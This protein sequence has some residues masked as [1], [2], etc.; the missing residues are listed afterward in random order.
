MQQRFFAEKAV[1]VDIDWDKISSVVQSDEGKRELASL[2]NTLLELERTVSHVETE[3][4]SPN[5]EGLKKQLDAKIVENFQKAYGGR[6][7]VGLG[8]CGGVWGIG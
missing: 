2:K 7:L 3:V 5:W 1:A 8:G 4:P 6:W